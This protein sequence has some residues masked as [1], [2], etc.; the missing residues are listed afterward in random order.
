MNI[1]P[2]AFYNE[3]QKHLNLWWQGTLVVSV[4]LALNILLY[5]LDGRM[6][7]D[8]ALWIKPIKFEISLIIH[9]T[10]LAVLAALLSP[11]RRNSLIWK[12]MTYAVVAAG[13]FEVMYIFLQ[14]A[15][16]RESHYNNSTVI[17]S[18]MYGL[19]GLG[20]VVLVAGSFYLGYLLYREYRSERS[21]VLLLSASLG[22]IIGSVLTL[23]IASYLSSATTGYTVPADEDVLRL[24]LFSWYLNGEDLRIPHFFATHMMQLF[25]LYGLWLSRQNV[26]MAD[27]KVRLFWSAGIYSLIVVLLFVIVLF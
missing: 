11:G 13:V 7:A 6:L 19:M 24:P 18:V 14:A 23:I 2:S 15:R 1:A 21:N 17:E 3:Q 4:F 9:F 12:G 8:D 26:S 20:A 10:T 22:L 16:G 5:L 25:P 27:C